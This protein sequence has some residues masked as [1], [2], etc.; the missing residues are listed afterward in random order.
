MAGAKFIRTILN[1]SKTDYKI[2]K[3]EKF[4][5]V[6]QGNNCITNRDKFNV[7]P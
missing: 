2:K 1:E 4:W 6:F 7:S 5:V 3:I